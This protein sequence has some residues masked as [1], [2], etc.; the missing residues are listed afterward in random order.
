MSLLRSHGALRDEEMR[1]PSGAGMSAVA[2]R[3]RAALGRI[4]APDPGFVVPEPFHLIRTTD[5]LHELPGA[6]GIA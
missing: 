5:E 1:L 4:D 3:I 2:R 6:S